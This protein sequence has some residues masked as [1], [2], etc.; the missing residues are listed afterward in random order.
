[1]QRG[2][3]PPKLPRRELTKSSRTGNVAKRNREKNGAFFSLTPQGIDN[4]P[5]LRARHNAAVR[6]GPRR[7]G[8][9]KSKQVLPRSELAGTYGIEEW[10]CRIKNTGA[11]SSQPAR[12]RCCYC[13][14]G[15]FSRLGGDSGHWKSSCLAH[16]EFGNATQQQ[17]LTLSSSSSSAT[18]PHA[19]QSI[20]RDPEDARASILSRVQDGGFCAGG[21][22]SAVRRNHR[23]NLIAV[24]KVFT[25]EL[26]LS[27]KGRKQTKPEW[28]KRHWKVK[29]HDPLLDPSGAPQHKAVPDMVAVWVPE[30]YLASA[31]EAYRL[32]EN[33]QWC[34]DVH[35]G[36]KL[37]AE[38]WIYCCV[39]TGSGEEHVLCAK[40]YRCRHLHRVTNETT[41]LGLLY[42][43]G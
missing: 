27:Y 29:P 1:M 5:G 17:Q 20:L 7:R 21:H 26:D 13:G 31:H 38:G 42:R 16:P 18:Q 34:P 14:K 30:H 10:Q 4:T 40:K 41:G 3:P 32:R 39:E 6:R 12:Y 33:A 9:G 22:D 23:K 11:G 2:P 28:F 8:G 43:P 24:A 36:H 15:P 25:K 19:S 35:C 37:H